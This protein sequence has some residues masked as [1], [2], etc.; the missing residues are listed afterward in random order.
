M[1][2]I[3]VIVILA[4]CGLGL[5]VSTNRQD[6]Q[7]S[8]EPSGTRS[9]ARS[10]GNDISVT[11]TTVSPPHNAQTE[12]E[13]YKKVRSIFWLAG[14]NEAPVQADL[15]IL[16]V[17]LKDAPPKIPFSLL[18]IMSLPSGK[19]IY[20]EKVQ[21]FPI[22]MYTRDLN[23]DK[24][25]ELIIIW[26]AGA[27]ASRIEIL[28]VSEDKITILLNEDYRVKADLIEKA[29]GNVDIVITT[30]ESG[31]GPFVSTRY[32]WKKGGVYQPV[33]QSPYRSPHYRATHK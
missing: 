7:E 6:D 19:I 22:T 9:S 26:E 25:E 12:S 31:A 30:G 3:T 24:Q 5:F 2:I 29:D 16:K 27:V 11:G 14:R 23:G 13:L 17:P 18:K 15:D 1:K 32:S 10:S 20:Q 33:S 4:L 21:D 8:A 28:S